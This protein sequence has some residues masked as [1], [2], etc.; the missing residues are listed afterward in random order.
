MKIMIVGN[1]GSG[2]S[3]LSRR[4]IAGNPAARLSLDEVVFHGGTERRR[5][6][7]GVADVKR[8][9]AE[10]ESWIIEGCYSD[11]IEPIL[12]GCEEL[13]SPNPGVDVCVAHCRARPWE[14]EKFRSKEEQDENLGNL[15]EWVRAYETR[16]DES[17][18]ARHRALYDSFKGKKRELTDPGEYERI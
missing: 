9:V 5:L 7:D 3:T 16:R 8:F 18:L 14:P 1:A 10:N 17:G 2:K 4:L 6:Q 15:I 12:T 11:I 13:I